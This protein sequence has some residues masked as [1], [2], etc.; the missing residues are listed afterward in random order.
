MLFNQFPV[1]D[2]PVTEANIRRPRQTTG[3]SVRDFQPFFGFEESPA[4][5][6][7]QLGQSL[8]TVDNLY[9]LSTLL[10]V[11]MNDILVAANLP[12][13]C[14]MSGR[15]EPTAHLLGF[16]NPPTLPVEVSRKKA[17]EPVFTRR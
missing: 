7:W 1:I 16:R 12:D 14:T 5:Y 11:S 6:K 10:D 9:A 15:P 3:L 13:M 17:L 2:L 8:P 4:I